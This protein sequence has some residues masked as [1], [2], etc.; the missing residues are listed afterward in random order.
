MDL[1]ILG[2][3]GFR[4]L[5]NSIDDIKNVQHFWRL[6]LEAVVDQLC[7]SDMG[8]GLG[9]TGMIHYRLKWKTSDKSHYGTVK[10]I[11]RTMKM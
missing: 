6:E 8:Q 1:H 11:T 5:R 2:R 10:C 3:N 9:G 7:L 4:F